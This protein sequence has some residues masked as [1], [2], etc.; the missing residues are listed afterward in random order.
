MNCKDQ[1]RAYL[2]QDCESRVRT[3]IRIKSSSAENMLSSS[4]QS[5]LEICI[6]KDQKNFEILRLLNFFYTFKPIT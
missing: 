6:F 3:W 1:N 5:S 4:L 2:D